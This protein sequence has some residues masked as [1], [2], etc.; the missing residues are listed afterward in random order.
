MLKK[1]DHMNSAESLLKSKLENF[2]HAPLPEAYERIQRR[3]TIA[4]P[5]RKEQFLKVVRHSVLTKASL[6]AN[7]VLVA[8]M[9]TVISVSEVDFSRFQFTDSDSE[10]V[11][12]PVSEPD[13]HIEEEV[14]VLD[15]AFVEELVEQ[16]PEAIEVKKAI[17][18]PVPVKSTISSV[19]EPKEEP[20]VQPVEAE[21]VVE[22]EI[23]NKTVVADPIPEPEIIKEEAQPQSEQSLIEQYLQEQ[24]KSKKVEKPDSTMK[25]FK[26]QK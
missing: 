19:K 2:E 10:N 22:S 3:M 8:A 14:P 20:I 16:Q 25:L 21:P 9:G 12:M 18:K 4:P 13:K 5:S 23:E 15:E 7:V 11:K 6:V 17:D 24:E 26:K 1:V